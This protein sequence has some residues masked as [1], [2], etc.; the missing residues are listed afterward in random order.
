MRKLFS[1]RHN[2]NEDRAPMNR[3]LHFDGF[4]ELIR[5]PLADTDK[6]SF[7]RIVSLLQQSH[8]T[9]AAPFALL[10]RRLVGKRLAPDEARKHWE[11]LIV[12]KQDMEE[13]L[14][15]EIDIQTAAVEHFAMNERRGRQKDH[16]RA[17][18]AKRTGK[19]LGARHI[20]PYAPDYHLAR[21][22]D[23]IQRSRRYSHALSAIMI[24]TGPLP[25]RSTDGQPEEPE[26]GLAAV[27]RIVERTIRAV[28]ILAP[29]GANRLLVILPDT[30]Q[31]EAQELAERIRASIHERTGRMPVF[32]RPVSVGIAAAQCNAEQ[33]AATFLRAIESALERSATPQPPQEPG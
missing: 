2:D 13:K 16:R 33:S 28:D 4:E 7:D 6:H 8:T 20:N 11:E 32:A 30:N 26:T 14:G 19:L 27:V 17:A 1:L 5:E 25:L 12:L 3:R 31:R 10:L 22:K 18:G 9:H 29:C 15:R 24:D 23:E 21:L